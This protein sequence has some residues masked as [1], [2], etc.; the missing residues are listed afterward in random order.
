MA[1]LSRPHVFTV[2]LEEYFQVEAFSDIVS[3]DQWDDFPSR[4]EPSARLLLDLLDE[5]GITGTFFVLGW[6]AT[7]HTALVREIADRG[8]ELACHSFWHRLVYQL[9]PKEFEADTRLSKEVIEQAAGVVVRGYRAPSFSVTRRSLWAHDVLAECG[10]T[11]D[12]SIFPIH[13]DIYG[14]ADAPRR[15]FRACR[16]RLIVCPMTTFRWFGQH[17][18]PVGGGGYL[19]L[20]PWT[21]TK[22][23]IRKAELE[24][25][26][27]ISYI[28]PWELDPEQPRMRARLRSKMRH[29]TNLHKTK[30]RV[31][32]L[33]A[34][35]RFSSFRDSQLLEGHGVDDAPSEGPWGVAEGSGTSGCHSSSSS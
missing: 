23:G 9:T 30:E 8:H 22:M 27:V 1:E 7:K 29:Y 10:L 20:L 21:Y 34:L 32:R 31:R 3:R 13:H 11:Y 28:H 35:R 5:A 33:L 16:G 15:P 2:D 19:R 18:W 12:A 24:D 17:N 6:V 14:I 26:P 25:I 4:V